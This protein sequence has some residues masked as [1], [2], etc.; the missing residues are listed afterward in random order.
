MI[1]KKVS[2]EELQKVLNKQAER[3]KLREQLKAELK[4]I[5]KGECLVYEA[6][7]GMGA[8]QEL[9][10]SAFASEIRGLK[11]ITEDNLTYIYKE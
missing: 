9:V 11:T 6:K 1:G 3:T 7:E 5:Q 4:G 10:L 2:S 8:I